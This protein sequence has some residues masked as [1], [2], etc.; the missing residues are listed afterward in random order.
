MPIFA[1]GTTGKPLPGAILKMEMDLAETREQ[2][3]EIVAGLL[4]CNPFVLEFKVK[5][6]PRGVVVTYEVTAEKM[7]ELANNMVK[8]DRQNEREETK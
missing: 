1:A 7:E 8:E 6:K 4:R 2:A 5:E 3:I